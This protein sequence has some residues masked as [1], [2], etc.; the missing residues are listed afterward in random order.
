LKRLAT[1]TLLMVALITLTACAPKVED[2]NAVVNSFMDHWRA[3]D[4][5]KMAALM[6]NEVEYGLII[7]DYAFTE[8]LSN[9]PA[10][11]GLPADELTEA[12]A[13]ED[14]TVNLTITKTEAFGDY[15]VVTGS[16]VDSVDPDTKG[17]MYFHLVNTDDGWKIR[18]IALSPDDL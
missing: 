16:Y 8:S 10:S 4:A 5:A 13:E 6:T 9:P 15:A 17:I 18:L 3:G 1:I 11:K 14:M 2:I 7:P 12:L